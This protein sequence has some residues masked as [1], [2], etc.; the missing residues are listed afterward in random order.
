[1]IVVELAS[2]VLDVRLMVELI[3]G[4]LKLQHIKAEPKKYVIQEGVRAI[5]TMM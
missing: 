4:G 3:V 5:A 2:I 1:M